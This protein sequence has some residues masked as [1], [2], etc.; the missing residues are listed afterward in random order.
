MAAVLATVLVPMA[1]DGYLLPHEVL[2]L[3]LVCREFQ[4][5]LVESSDAIW[6][7][8]LR[9]YGGV[10][11]PDTRAV[12]FR[13]PIR[14]ILASPNVL[15]LQKGR[16][17]DLHPWIATCSN[18][19]VE[20]QRAYMT[21]HIAFDPPQWSIY[22]RSYECKI[23]SIA[24]AKTSVEVRFQVVTD[25]SAG[26]LQHPKDSAL[27]IGEDRIHPSMMWFVVANPMEEYAGI[28]RFDA[29]AV[30]GDVLTFEYGFSGY[31]PAVLARL[32]SS[33]VRAHKLEHLVE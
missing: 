27:T 16:T 7:A 15:I 30:L 11:A 9:R 10:L 32:T 25:G 17:Y 21:R 5:A 19:C 8:F 31:S 3:G 12:L 4:A 18:P 2:R 24:V 6:M 29:K 33:F 13:S 1:V 28:L 26:P 23:T 14:D 22:N 20:F